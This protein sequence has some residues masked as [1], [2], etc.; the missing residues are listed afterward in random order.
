M[1]VS[2]NVQRALNS[3]SANETHFCSSKPEADALA[4]GF[5]M[6]KTVRMAR[7]VRWNNGTAQKARIEYM[8]KVWN[9]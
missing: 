5:R 7:V 1:A 9:A 6:N 4:A 8:V 3:R 2:G